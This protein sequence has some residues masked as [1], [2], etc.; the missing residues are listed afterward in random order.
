MS[1]DDLRR[2]LRL[3]LVVGSNDAPLGLLET[4][5]AALEGGVTSVQLREKRGTDARILSVA[6]QVRDL[7][8]DHDAAFF[9]NDRLD[10]A[11]AAG[12]DGVH[13]GVDDLPI[14]AARRIAGSPFAIGY[15]PENDMQTRSAKLEGASYLGI[16][17][18]FGSVSKLDAGAAIGLS[19]LRRR[20]EISGL[21][22][23]G[24]GGI[25]ASNAA[26]VIRA[27]ASGVAVMNA[28]LR[29]PNPFEAA[30]GLREAV[31]RAF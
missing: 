12:A 2:R 7:C 30:Q 26:D 14:P 18:V 19:V 16:G 10:L 24:I 1:F 23:V 17:P 8:N 13:L 21:P 31:D 9:L 28:I 20:S 5:E 22:V 6:E 25:D 15:S 11:L 4:V 29:S 27:G 3:Y